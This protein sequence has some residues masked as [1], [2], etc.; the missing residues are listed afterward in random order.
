M[1]DYGKTSCFPPFSISNPAAPRPGLP[2]GDE[3][4]DAEFGLDEARKRRQGVVFAEDG[5][6]ASAGGGEGGIQFGGQ[7]LG[8]GEA[9]HDP[10]EG[11]AVIQGKELAE[12]LDEF[13][14][15]HG[16][17]IA[18]ADAMVGE[19]AFHAAFAG[20][21][22]FFAAGKGGV[23]EGAVERGIEVGQAGAEAQAGLQG[24]A[25]GGFPFAGDFGGRGLAAQGGGGGAL[26]ADADLAGDF[27]EDPGA[28]FAER[29]GGEHG[30]G[31]GQQEGE[32][33]VGAGADEVAVHP[34]EAAEGGGGVGKDGFHGG[35]DGCGNWG[36]QGV[37]L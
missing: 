37:F 3:P 14:V 18:D 21:D 9:V 35:D 22:E 12:A 5:R 25:R 28:D 2:D 32:E 29:E 8:V 17:G 19:P 20:A 10:F 13:L 24:A 30:G 15:A 31:D 16:G 23:L 6:E 1:R 33:A 36:S 4:D 7:A 26:F 27:V 34:V 11:N